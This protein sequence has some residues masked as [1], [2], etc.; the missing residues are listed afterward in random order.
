M[1]LV[2]GTRVS[3]SNGPYKS[4]P[5]WHLNQSIRFRKTHRCAQRQTDRGTCDICS[6]RLHACDACDAA[7]KA[8]YHC[9]LQIV[10]L[11]KQQASDFGDAGW[12]G[13]EAGVYVLAAANWLRYRTN[14]DGIRKLCLLGD[15]LLRRILLRST[16]YTA[17]RRDNIQYVA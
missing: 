15:K 1:V 10:L 8:K 7:R 13:F 16:V 11:E 9:S 6:N 17:K 3:P 5:E 4:S 14:V 12:V 2:C